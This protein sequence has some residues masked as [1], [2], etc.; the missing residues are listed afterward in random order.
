MSDLGC[1]TGALAVDL[2]AAGHVVTGVDPAGPILE[3]ARAR[4]GGAQ[5]RWIHGTAADLPDDAD[6]VVMEGTWGDF[7]GAA[8]TEHSPEFILL[9]QR[10]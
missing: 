4:P 7:S 6:L 9:A 2:A 5:V 10:A 1:G 3:I 8:L